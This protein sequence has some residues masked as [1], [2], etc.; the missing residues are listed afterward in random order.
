MTENTTPKRSSP[1][2]LL[3]ALRLILTIAT[4]IVLTVTAVRLVMTPAFLHFEYNRPNFPPDPFGFTLEDRL[5][6]AP[7]SVA[8][9]VNNADIS[10]LGDLRLPREKVPPGICVPVPEDDSLCSM[11]NERELRHM[12]DVKVVTRYTFITGIISVILAGASTAYLIANRQFLTLR[13]GYFSGA[14]LTLGLIGA[15]IVVSITSWNAFFTAFHGIFFE[16]DS[17]LFR[18]SD[19]L[20]RLFPEQF[21]FDAAIII[22]GLVGIAAMW[23]AVL[24]GYWGWLSAKRGIH[25]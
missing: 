22:G 24:M 8:Y 18:Y 6:Y 9:L 2:W 4:P 23:I 16:G 17:W 11:F 19:T 20:I 7:P 10:F 12:Y 15:I 1:A 3:T 5:T 21:W 14:V 25:A 13:T